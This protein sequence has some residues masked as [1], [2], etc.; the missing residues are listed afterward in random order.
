[1]DG[2]QGV[3][4]TAT[5]VTFELEDPEDYIRPA[6]EGTMGILKSAAKHRCVLRDQVDQNATF[7]ATIASD[8]KRVVVT[9]SI[10]AVGESIVSVE[11]TKVYTEEDWNENAVRLVKEIG[12]DAS[13]MSKYNASKVLSEQG[14]SA[15]TRGQHASFLRAP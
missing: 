9:S 6:L 15:G 5:P 8:I 12:K 11:K 2:V 13:G 10:G 7:N 3:V 1:M 14:T 4:H